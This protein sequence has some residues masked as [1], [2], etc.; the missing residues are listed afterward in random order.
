VSISGR[1]AASFR[2]YYYLRIFR[3]HLRCPISLFVHND[4]LRKRQPPLYAADVDTDPAAAARSARS[5]RKLSPQWH[6]FIT[7]TN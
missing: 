6:Q 3:D 2:D 4:V 7:V 1:A 5:P